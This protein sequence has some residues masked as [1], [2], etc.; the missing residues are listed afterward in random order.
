MVQSYS[1][2]VVKLHS[3]LLSNGSMRPICLGLIEH[4]QEIEQLY[5]FQ[6]FKDFLNVACS[7][8]QGVRLKDPEIHTMLAL[9]VTG[10]GFNSTTV[11]YLNNAAVLSLWKAF[12]G[13]ISS[14]KLLHPSKML[15]IQILL[16][17]RSPQGFEQCH[18]TEEKSIDEFGIKMTKELSV[19]DRAKVWEIKKFAERFII[20]HQHKK[21]SL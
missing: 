2:K 19:N 5:E 8:I 16:Q 7:R 21:G 11:S 13:A 3:G 15:D 9:C 20:S 4:L 17:G 6:E 18:P 14:Y 10:Y 1:S 12:L